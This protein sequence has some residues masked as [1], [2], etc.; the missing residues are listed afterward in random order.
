[1]D[2]RIRSCSSFSEWKKA[3]A[4]VAGFIVGSGLVWMVIGLFGGS[5]PGPDIV[6]FPLGFGLLASPII[7]ALVAYKK[8]FKDEPFKYDGRRPR[9][10]LDEAAGVIVIPLKGREI[11]FPITN[12]VVHVGSSTFEHSLPRMQGSHTMRSIHIRIE[13]CRIAGS[14]GV[15]YFHHQEGWS[16]DVLPDVDTWPPVENGDASATNIRYMVYEREFWPFVKALK[17]AVE[18]DATN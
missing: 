15:F 7:F 10:R 8:T 3:V 5:F 11:K 4:S 1:M 2:M 6:R 16:T 9:I 18:D 17:L 13:I 14:G 12:S